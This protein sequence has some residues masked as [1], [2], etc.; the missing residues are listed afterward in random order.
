MALSLFSTE[1]A[2]MI[3]PFKKL[4][5][6]SPLFKQP[7]RATASQPFRPH[8]GFP[9]WKSDAH[10]DKGSNTSARFSSILVA[11][12]KTWPPV[13][14]NKERYWNILDTLLFLDTIAVTA[15]TILIAC[16]FFCLK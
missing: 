6:S 16:L 13:W 3:Y 10:R 15:V 12:V 9:A 14:M 1:I 7:F 5:M 2:I 4:A 8:L 11:D